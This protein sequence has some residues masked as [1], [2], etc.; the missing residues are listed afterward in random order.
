MFVVSLVVWLDSIYCRCASMSKCYLHFPVCCWC[1]YIFVLASISFSFT[2]TLC[3][4]TH[5]WRI[6]SHFTILFI[7]LS[8]FCTL[9]GFFSSLLLFL[10]PFS[11]P[12]N[13]LTFFSSYSFVVNITLVLQSRPFHSCLYAA[14]FQPKQNRHQPLLVLLLFMDHN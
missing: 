6:L 8:L 13:H 2:L 12:F 4:F 1:C 9:F 5:R 11:V 3:L 10:L 14:T 7:Y